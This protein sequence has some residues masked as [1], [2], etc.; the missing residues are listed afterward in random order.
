MEKKAQIMLIAA[1]MLGSAVIHWQLPY[2]EYFGLWGMGHWTWIGILSGLVSLISGFIIKTNPLKYT[3]WIILG[4][5]LTVFLRVV[6][7]ILFIDK[8]HHNLWPFEL[9]FAGTVSAVFC[10]PIAALIFVLRR[11]QF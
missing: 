11:K 5:V 9:I 8:T 3:H 4:V 2:G 10:Y 1:G 7:D 6:F